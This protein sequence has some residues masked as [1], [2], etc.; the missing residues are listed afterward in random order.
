MEAQAPIHL[1]LKQY[2]EYKALKE[3]VDPTLVSKVISCESSWISDVKG[4]GGHSIGISQINLPSHK[5]FT[6]EKA[7]DPYL[8]IDWLVLKLKHGEGSQWT[9]FRSRTPN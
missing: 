8:A 1:T 5:N 3:G 6:V 9:C 7:E 4:D 2:A